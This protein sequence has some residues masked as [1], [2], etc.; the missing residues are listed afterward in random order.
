VACPAHGVV[1]AVVPWARPG[2]RFTRAFED[3]AAWL[4]A[5]MTGTRAAQLLRTTWRSVQGIVER[6][7]ADLAGRTTGWRGWSGSG[8]MRSLIARTAGS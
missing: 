8:S 6:V 1:V 7:V 5:R 4:C 2:S 3:Q